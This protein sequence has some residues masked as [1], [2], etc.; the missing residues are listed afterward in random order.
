MRLQLEFVLVELRCLR[1]LSAGRLVT[2]DVLNA[3][4]DLSFIFINRLIGNLHAHLLYLVFV[5]VVSLYMTAIGTFIG[6]RFTD[7]D[8]VRGAYDF[9][10]IGIE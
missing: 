2:Q 8:G 5:V 1:V 7:G 4:G 3:R 10:S 6:F 9:T